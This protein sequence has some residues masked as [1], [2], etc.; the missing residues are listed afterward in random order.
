MSPSE[1]GPSRVPISAKAGQTG[2][3]GSMM[4][5]SDL[6]IE[7]PASLSAEMAIS[8]D[9]FDRVQAHQYLLRTTPGFVSDNTRH[10]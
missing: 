10:R 3:S 9:E 4:W 1:K 6:V 5:I 8:I 7:Y 2:R